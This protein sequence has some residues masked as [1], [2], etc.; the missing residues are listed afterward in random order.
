MNFSKDLKIKS[1]ILFDIELSVSFGILIWEILSGG[2]LPFSDVKFANRVQFLTKIK[3][4]LRPNP[5]AN[6]NKDLVSHM[7]SRLVKVFFLF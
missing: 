2:S 7:I 3:D 6:A 4:G 5:V 1:F